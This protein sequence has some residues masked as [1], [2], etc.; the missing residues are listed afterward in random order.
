MGS[1]I[2]EQLGHN[3][4]METLRGFL[5]ESKSKEIAFVDEIH[6]IGKKEQ[7]IL[8][9]AMDQKLLIL[10]GDANRRE[11]RVAL[12]DFTLIGATTDHIYCDHPLSTAS[13]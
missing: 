3:L 1:E 4:T 8:Y 6:L 10:G 12:D 11:C 2:H 5:M 13:G 7:T 9:R